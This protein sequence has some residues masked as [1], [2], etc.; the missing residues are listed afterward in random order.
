MKDPT[1]TSTNSAPSSTRIITEVD[2]SST[3]SLSEIYNEVVLHGELIVTIPRSE[4]RSLRRGLA[5]VKN[6]INSKLRSAG[7]T[8]EPLELSYTITTSPEDEELIN[9]QVLLRRR[10]GITVVAMQLP[11]DEI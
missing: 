3:L 2:T 11:D 8:P 6:K 9:V 1:S 4:E 7:I 10:G 5:S